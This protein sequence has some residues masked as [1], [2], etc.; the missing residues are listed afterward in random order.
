VAA[1]SIVGRIGMTVAAVNEQELAIDA[2]GTYVPRIVLE[3]GFKWRCRDLGRHD[4]RNYQTD[5]NRQV[6][7]PSV[8]LAKPPV[9]S[10]LFDVYQI[11]DGIVRGSALS[12]IA[13]VPPL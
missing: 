6:L 3:A 1:I 12:Q 2:A 8:H 9:R 11:G 4:K 5:G 7:Q 10:Q 13:D